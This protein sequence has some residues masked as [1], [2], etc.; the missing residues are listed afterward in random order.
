MKTRVWGKFGEGLGST[1]RYGAVEV[2]V[3]WKTVCR[4]VTRCL[5]S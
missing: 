4:F 3:E 5:M 2:A 1:R